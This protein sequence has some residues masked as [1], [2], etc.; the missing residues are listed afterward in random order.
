MNKFNWTDEMIAYIVVKRNAN[1]W[2]WEKIATGFNRRFQTKKSQSQVSKFYR[3]V[4]L[5]PVKPYT[6][7][8]IDLFILELKEQTS[9]IKDQIEQS[10]DL[11]ANFKIAA[12]LL[13]R[14]YEI[15]HIHEKAKVKKSELELGITHVVFDI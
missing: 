12:G 3:T 13:N 15:S 1:Q 8:E 5:N 6:V 7:E 2:T 4:I 14:F 10:V 9:F 11:Y